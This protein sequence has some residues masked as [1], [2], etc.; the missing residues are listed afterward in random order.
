MRIYTGFDTEPHLGTIKKC[1]SAS[2]MRLGSKM[3]L[4]AFRK[5]SWMRLDANQE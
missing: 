5:L 2:K 4:G 1:L 3:S